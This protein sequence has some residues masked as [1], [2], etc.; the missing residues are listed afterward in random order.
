M[1][2]RCEDCIGAPTWMIHGTPIISGTEQDKEN[3]KREE[4]V[5]NIGPPCNYHTYLKNIKP[6]CREYIEDLT[7]RSDGSSGIRY[8]SILLS[9]RI[10]ICFSRVAKAGEE[11]LSPLE[12]FTPEKESFLIMEWG[13]KKIGRIM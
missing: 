1:T 6:N 3:A 9:A 13:G 11:V 8:G 7:P 4:T 12:N 5:V 2:D 10:T